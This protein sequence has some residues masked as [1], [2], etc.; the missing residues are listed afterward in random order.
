MFSMV[1]LCLPLI[2]EGQLSVSGRL[3]AFNR[4]LSLHKKN[5]VRKADQFDRA[6]IVLTGPSNQTEPKTRQNDVPMTYEDIEFPDQFSHLH[7]LIRAFATRLQ[8]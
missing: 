3:T 4:R 8:N 5:V 7:S 6:L 1:T 2:Q